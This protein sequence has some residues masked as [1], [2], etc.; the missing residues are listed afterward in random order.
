[1]SG[2]AATQSGP[3]E[4]VGLNHCTGFSADATE[5][6]VFGMSGVGSDLLVGGAAIILPNLSLTALSIL[7][8]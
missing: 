6:T 2:E 4:V 5:I 8:G 1:M 3:Y 7:S